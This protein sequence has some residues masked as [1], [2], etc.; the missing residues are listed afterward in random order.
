[1]G[2]KRIRNSTVEFLTFTSQDDTQSIE[3]R[4]E[5]ETVWLSQKLMATLFDVDV[6]T[7]S[8]HLKNIFESGE[9]QADAVIRKFRITATDGKN[10]LTQFYNLDA[11]I[12]QK[13]ELRNDFDRELE[14]AIRV[15]P[16]REK[17]EGK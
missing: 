6:R 10:Y 2:E 13:H 5:D 14:E 4:Y 11:I 17:R 8:E 9:L 1:M 12:I 7:I 15:L 3:A 16:D